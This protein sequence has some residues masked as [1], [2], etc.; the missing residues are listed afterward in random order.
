MP[1]VA[2]IF[3]A[4]ALTWGAI[5]ARR[6]PIVLSCVAL[7]IVGYVFG[8]DFWHL[9]I[10]PVPLTLDRLV[11][12]GVL[13]AFVVRW[14]HGQIERKSISGSEWFLGGLIAFLAA[15]LLTSGRP[16]VVAPDAGT[17]LWRFIASF[18]IPA[19][20]YLIA[21]QAPLGRREWL[22]GLALMSALGLYLALTGIAEITQQWALVFPHYI[23]DP[24]LGIHFGRA[25]GPDLNSASLGVYLTAC[26]WCAWTLRPHVRRGWQ[27]VLL[28]SMALMAFGVFL[29]FTRSTWIGLLASGCVVAAVELPRRWRLPVF[30]M[31]AM[32]GVLVAAVVWSSVIGLKREGTAAEA[33][34]SVDQRESFAYVSWQM[35][36]DHPVLGV[37]FGRFYDR[38]L[39]YL[40]DRSQD[41]ELESLRPLHHHNTLLG[42]LTETGLIGLA[43]FLGLLATWARGA[44]SLVR[45]SGDEAPPWIRSQ[46]LLMLTVLVGY[47]SSAVFHDLTLIPSQHWL[48]FVMAGIT[49]NVRCGAKHCQPRVLS[50]TVTVPSSFPMASTA[51]AGAA[52]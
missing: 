14:R 28:A 33:H 22:A 50:N 30:G 40:S 39:P 26:L 13:A 51:A 47:L 42:L 20:L 16:E 36:K 21:R 29:T 41:F 12:M 18:V 48:L 44:W 1:V 38:K 4:A 8:H 27:L 23:S 31:A 9:K 43:A 49:S 34:H 11:L 15:S 10:G 45:C 3:G 6:G 19:M 25:R 7:L 24:T 52:R 5:Y 37:G 35:F 17:P 2:L 46:G 32:V